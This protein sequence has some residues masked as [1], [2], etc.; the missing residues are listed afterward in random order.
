M[1]DRYRVIET[2]FDPAT[3]DALQHDEH[4]LGSRR[5]NAAAYDLLPFADPA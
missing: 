2:G 4:A 1:T 5:K 3:T